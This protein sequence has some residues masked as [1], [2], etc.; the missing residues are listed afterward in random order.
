MDYWFTEP[1]KDKMFIENIDEEE[2]DPCK[3]YI[4]N[5]N[6]GGDTTPPL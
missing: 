1:N 5:K 6:K 2:E 3:G 4:I